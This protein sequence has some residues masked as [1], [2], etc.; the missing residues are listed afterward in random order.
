MEQTFYRGRLQ[1]QFAIETLILRLTIGRRSI[2]SSST[3]FV[4]APSARRRGIIICRR[5]P[6]WRSRGRKGL[7]SAVRRLACWCLPSSVRCRSLTPRRS[8]RK[9]RST[10][11]SLQDRRQR[12]EDLRQTLLQVG[13]KGVDQRRARAVEGADQADGKRHLDAEAAHHY[14][15]IGIVQGG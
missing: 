3:N 10:L 4:S 14:A 9:T 1:E 11:C 8:T 12:R 2:R 15:A 13:N 7:F 5:S 6:P